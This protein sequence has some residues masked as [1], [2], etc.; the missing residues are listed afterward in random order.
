MKTGLEN[1]RNLAILS[2]LLA[3]MAI[4]LVRF[5]KDVFIGGA[6]PP[7]ATAAPV[8]QQQ[9]VTSGGA[10]P[11]ARR[12]PS[13][14]NL[15]P[16]LHPELMAGAESLE[17]TGDGRN[18]FSMSSAPAQVKIEAVKGKVRPNG[19]M[20]AQG[21]QGPPPPPSIDLTFFGYASENGSKQAFLLHGQ[22]VYIAREGDVVDHHY[23]IL[24]INPLSI[25][26]TDLLYNNTQTLPLVQG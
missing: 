17:Y 23:K 7:V 1:K 2:V 22:D 3:V 24:R 10:S 16:T 15:D 19:S 20:V 13:L 8:A 12:L 9:A 25:E 6:P 21:P 5:V 14:E 11:A 26:V 4:V 18:I